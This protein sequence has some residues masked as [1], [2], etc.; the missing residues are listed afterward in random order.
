MTIGRISLTARHRSVL[1]NNQ[2]NLATVADLQQQLSSG[3]RISAMSD[4]Q[5]LVVAVSCSASNRPRA[6]SYLRNVQRQITALDAAD[7]ALSEVGEVMDAIKAAAVQGA[8]STQDAT[9]RRALAGTVEAQL[10][11]LLDL[12]NTVHD[13]RSI[14]AG[15]A[16]DQRPF[17]LSED[18]SDVRY[19]GNQDTYE[20]RIS[21]FESIAINDP[22]DAIFQGEHSIFDAV[23]ELRQAL[24]NNDGQVS[25]IASTP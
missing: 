1:A 21:R 2:S 10:N 16:V 8:D 17:V 12:S 19:Q 5:S 22:G 15:T 23:L 18:G 20:I 14:F 4:V 9:S 13:G 24:L 25:P 3:K 7:T 6:K 11:R